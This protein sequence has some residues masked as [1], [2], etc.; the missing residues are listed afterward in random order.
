MSQ[1]YGPFY[2]IIILYYITISGSLWIIPS[3]L[4]LPHTPGR[5][6]SFIRSGLD[7]LCMPSLSFRHIDVIGGRWL[8]SLS[9]SSVRRVSGGVHWPSTC[10]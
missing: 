4:I 1:Y 6:V 10:R 9:S 8:G 2:H 7:P 3:P 5:D